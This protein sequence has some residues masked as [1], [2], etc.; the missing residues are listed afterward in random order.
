M[1]STYSSL[2]GVQGVV[3]GVRGVVLRHSS[4]EGL[5]QYVFELGGGGN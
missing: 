4:G 3:V 1:F 2:N 5:V